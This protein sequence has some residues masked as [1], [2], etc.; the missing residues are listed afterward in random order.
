MGNF[1]TEISAFHK[2]KSIWLGSSLQ[3]GPIINLSEDRFFYGGFGICLNYFIVKFN[4]Y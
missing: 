2:Y 4:L 3:M 1:G